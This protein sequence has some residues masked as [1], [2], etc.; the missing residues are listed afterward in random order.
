MSNQWTRRDFLGTTLKSAA[1][2]GAFAWSPHGVR[3]TLAAFQEA[4]ASEQIFAGAQRDVLKAAVDV[5]VPSGGEMPAASDIGAVN[6]IDALSRELPSIKSQVEDGLESIGEISKR[7]FDGDFLALSSEQ[8]VAV[9]TEMES[10]AA[11]ATFAALRG[12]VYE[13]YY[14]SPEVWK[15]IGYEFYP[16]YESGLHMAPLD[17]GLLAPVRQRPPL[18][19][20][21][22]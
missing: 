9:L 17:E 8:R 4:A 19:K 14:T 7:L 22:D 1:A 6:Y 10:R 12:F 5:L 18:F 3:L 15:L 21:V 16:T 11:P 2:A 20:E 13:A